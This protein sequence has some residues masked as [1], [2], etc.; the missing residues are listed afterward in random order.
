MLLTL[1]SRLPR[2]WS[3]QA[4][5]RSLVATALGLACTLSHALAVSHQ[6]S[7]LADLVN[8][9]DLWQVDYTVTGPLAT[10]E[11]VNL[12]FAPDLYSAIHPLSP[13]SI[14]SLDALLITADPQLGGDTQLILTATQPL[15][16]SFSAKVSVQLVWLG[17]GQPGSLPYEWLDTDFNVKATALSTPTSA[18]P[19]VSGLALAMIGMGVAWGFTR[20][21]RRPTRAKARH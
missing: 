10:F 20:R 3:A 14:G 7:N 9:Q 5:R 8:G 18:V 4:V 19:E 13:G 11:A 17:L 12:L 16:A 1:T 15:A 6:A 2:R 21:D